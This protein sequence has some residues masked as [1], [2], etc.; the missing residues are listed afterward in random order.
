MDH[1]DVTRYWIDPPPQ[2]SAGLA[3]WQAKIASGWRPNRRISAMGYYE[4]S[5]F[6]GVYIWEYINVIRPL[7]ERK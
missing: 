4:A 3:K 2:P 5:E 7:L 6:Y 1:I